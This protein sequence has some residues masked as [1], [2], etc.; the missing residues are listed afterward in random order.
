VENQVRNVPQITPYHFCR[1]P[2]PI[3]FALRGSQNYRSLALYNTCNR[4]IAASGIPRLFP[5]VFIVVRLPENRVVS[6][7]FKVSSTFQVSY[8]F[9]YQST[10]HRVISSHGHVVTQS[11]TRLLTRCGHTWRHSSMLVRSRK[12]DLEGWR[13]SVV[14]KEPHPH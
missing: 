13:T 10:R 7:N 3:N 1:I 4:C 14:H 12:Y 9:G 5:S 6:T 11:L 8:H 2:Q